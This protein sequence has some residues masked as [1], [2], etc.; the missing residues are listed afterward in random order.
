M[1]K[2]RVAL[3]DGDGFVTKGVWHDAFSGPG[4]F[5]YVGD[6][7]EDGRDDVVSFDHTPGADVHVALSSGTAFG[8][9]RKWNDFFGIPGETSL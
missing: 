4:A 1:A 5:P 6:F 2:V 3:S 8:E 9:S 7:D